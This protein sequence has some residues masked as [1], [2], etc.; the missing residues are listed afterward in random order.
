[1]VL[2][3]RGK[4]HECA[5][6]ENVLFWGNRELSY[7]DLGRLFGPTQEGLAC[8]NIRLNFEGGCVE[9]LEGNCV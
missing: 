3:F 4:G 5:F 1:M 6:W 7:L 2:M 8:T 9:G